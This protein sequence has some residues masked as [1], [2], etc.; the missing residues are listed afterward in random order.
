LTYL[1][2]TCRKTP[3]NQSIFSHRCIL[4]VDAMVYRQSVLHWV[5]SVGSVYSWRTSDGLPYLVRRLSP[6]L[7]PK[8]H[9]TALL[10][11]LVAMHW[12]WWHINVLLKWLAKSLAVWSDTDDATACLLLVPSIAHW[13]STVATSDHLYIRCFYDRRPVEYILRVK[14]ETL[15]WQVSK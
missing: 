3:I 14:D 7:F 15:I 8:E 6:S 1:V 11:W 2:L 5:E 13:P 10:R 4:H 9:C 12:M